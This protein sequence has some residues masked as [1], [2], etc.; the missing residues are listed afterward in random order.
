MT[1]LLT[2][3]DRELLRRLREEP[4][5]Y[6]LLHRGKPLDIL[7]ALTNPDLFWSGIA[8]AP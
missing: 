1:T 3:P 5:T 4:T 2:D 7:E 6:E 8:L